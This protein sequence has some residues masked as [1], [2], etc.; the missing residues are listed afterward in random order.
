MEDNWYALAIAILKKCTVEQSFELF[1]RGRMYKGRKK[2]KED[3]EDMLKLRENLKSK[4]VAQIYNISPS[5]ISRLLKRAKKRAAPT[6][7]N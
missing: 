2:S 1:E 4:E 3:L 7:R 6:A 5:A